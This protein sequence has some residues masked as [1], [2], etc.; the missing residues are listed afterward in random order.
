MNG[1]NVNHA[2]DDANR[3]SNELFCPRSTLRFRSRVCLRLKYRYIVTN[4][5]D[6]QPRVKLPVALSSGRAKLVW[7]VGHLHRVRPVRKAHV[8]TGRFYRD[9]FGMT[10]VAF[11]AAFGVAFVAELRHRLKN[12]RVSCVGSDSYHNCS[13]SRSGTIISVSIELFGENSAAAIR[14]LCPL[15]KPSNSLFSKLQR[16]IRPC[17]SPLKSVSPSA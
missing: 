10:S 4:N 3:I 16:A 6:F 8:P 2:T 15:L 13:G 5:R 17:Q 1:A 12:Q 14:S 7:I 11:G 9:A